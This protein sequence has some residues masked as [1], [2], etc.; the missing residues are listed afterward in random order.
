M[1]GWET[2]KK[3]PNRVWRKSYFSVQILSLSVTLGPLPWASTLRR[4]G[5]WWNPQLM[6]LMQYNT[7]LKCPSLQFPSILSNL[8]ENTDNWTESNWWGHKNNFHD[9]KLTCKLCQNSKKYWTSAN[10]STLLWKKENEEKSKTGGCLKISQNISNTNL[11]LWFWAGCDFPG[12]LLGVLDD[13]LPS[14]FPGVLW[15]VCVVL[16]VGVFGVFPGVLADFGLRG[17]KGTPKS[18][19]YIQYHH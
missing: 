6:T 13:D 16:A 8:N 2:S 12:V 1:C 19:I 14:C 10:M 5:L 7:G 11:S 4:F 9:G 17:D 3:S 15:G 18:T